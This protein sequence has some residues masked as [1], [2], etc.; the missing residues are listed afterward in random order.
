MSTIIQRLYKVS[1]R[2]MGLVVFFSRLLSQPIEGSLLLPVLENL[3]I[4]SIRA[5]F[6]ESQD[7]VSGD[8]L[9]VDYLLQPFLGILELFP[10][11]GQ[12]SKS[13]HID[14]LSLCSHLFII[15]NTW[16]C[17]IRI[18]SPQLPDVEKRLPVNIRYQLVQVKVSDLMAAKERRFH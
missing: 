8:N 17:S 15:E 9:L 5:G 18:F 10:I 2:Q 12:N 3:N 11:P 13:Y 7:G 4:F 1:N 6:I 16:I 14:L